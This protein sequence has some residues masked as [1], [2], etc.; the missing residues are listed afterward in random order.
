MAL[1]RELASSL[2]P[3]KVKAFPKQKKKKESEETDLWIS[4]APFEK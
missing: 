4:L 3:R 2:S 1:S